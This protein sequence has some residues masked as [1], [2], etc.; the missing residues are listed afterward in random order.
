MCGLYSL[1]AIR[2]DVNKGEVGCGYIKNL[3]AD[4][5]KQVASGKARLRMF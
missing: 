2:A 4:T 1:E 3:F 5:G